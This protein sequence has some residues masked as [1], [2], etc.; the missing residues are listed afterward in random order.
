MIGDEISLA[1]I[2]LFPF[3][4]QFMAIKPLFQGI[5]NYPNL[6]QWLEN[7]LKRPSFEKVM[8]KK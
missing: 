2:H 3:A 5:E 7:I 4:R 8:E 6:I 1:D